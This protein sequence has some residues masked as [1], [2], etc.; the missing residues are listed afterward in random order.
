M[1][2]LLALL[3]LIPSFLN[4]QILECYINQDSYSP[5]VYFTV[6]KSELIFNNPDGTKV[7]FSKVIGNDLYNLYEN[8]RKDPKVTWKLNKIDLSIIYNRDSKKDG[9]TIGYYIC[10]T[11][12]KKIE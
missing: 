1:K 11:V 12:D 3:L 8:S 6:E 5:P 4:S 2:T 9:K 7:A 10:E